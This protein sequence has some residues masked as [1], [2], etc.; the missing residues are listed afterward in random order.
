MSHQPDLPLIEDYR[1]Y[2][3]LLAEVQLRPWLRAKVDLSDIVQ[4]TL[5]EAHKGLRCFRGRSEQ[6]FAAWLRRILARNIANAARDLHRAKRD[7]HREQ[8]LEASLDRSSVRLEAFLVSDTPSPSQLATR[9]EQVARLAEAL[10][11]LPTA[12][13]EAVLAHYLQG[14]PLAEVAHQMQRST[15]AVMGLLHRGLV[16]L[17]TL[18][19]DLE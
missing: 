2:L 9:N 11:K 10:G 18:L 14:M 8:S 17:R 13:H 3:A 19:Q 6:E 4:E 7:L 12:Q 16:Q 1:Q 15:S 5:L